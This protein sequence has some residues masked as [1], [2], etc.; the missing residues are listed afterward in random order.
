[1]SKTKFVLSLVTVMLILTLTV[2][3]VQAQSDFPP[4]LGELPDLSQLTPRDEAN[5]QLVQP[6][7]LNAGVVAPLSPASQE[8]VYTKTP[9]FYFTRSFEANRYRV[10]IFN[11]VTSEIT[12]L[13]GAGTCDSWYCY[14]QPS[15]GLKVLDI[16]LGGG[17]YTWRV[18]A[19]FG[20]TWQAP[21]SAVMFFV[22]SKGF[23]STFDVNRKGWIDIRDT[24]TLT[25]KGQ[26][27]TL[28]GSPSTYASVVQK[29]YVANFDYSVTMKRKNS[30][31]YNGLILWGFPNPLTTNGFWD[32]GIYFMI[33]NAG[34]F[35]MYKYEGG[36]YTSISSAKFTTAIKQYDWN[37]VR[38]VGNSPY[39]DIW[40]NGEYLGWID[41]TD[42]LYDYD[43]GHVG[44]TMAKDPAGN[45]A[46]MVDK[47]SLK[48]DVLRTN[49]EHDPT[50]ELKPAPDDAVEPALFPAIDLGDATGTR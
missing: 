40:I 35:L 23:T 4:E 29:D 19:R 27:K 38:I 45:D 42:Y 1:M 43:T 39:L 15:T 24:W 44:I 33:S 25:P 3:P 11:V 10:E 41:M 28:G 21:S 46:L 34:A 2:G 50:M 17:W 18:T 32:D 49:L 20:E 7:G 9:K 22:F 16:G 14:L 13:T 8:L 30:T 26:L 5:P 36:I 48:A 37:T 12:T 6:I 47:A 31:F